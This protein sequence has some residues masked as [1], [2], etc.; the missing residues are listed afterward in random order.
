MKKEHFSEMS[1]EINAPR[2]HD[3]AAHDMVL[4]KGAEAESQ[5]LQEWRNMFDAILDPVVILDP[6]FTI[7]RANSAAY[8]VLADQ[9]QEILGRRCHTLFAGRQEPCHQCPAQDV[10]HDGCPHE[11]TINHGFLGRTFQVSCA[12]IMRDGKLVGIVHTA[13]DI[14]R[15]LQLE[16]QLLQAQ[17]MEAIATLAGG[18]AHD[19]NN[20]LGSILGNTDLLLYRLQ[21]AA[22]RPGSA[23]RLPTQGEIR[24]HLEAIKTAGLRARDLVRQILAFSRRTPHSC[25]Y[26]L[27]SPI[28]KEAVKLLRAS[29]PATIELKAEIAADIATIYGDPTQIHQVLMDLCT[30]AVQALPNQQGCIEIALRQI[31]AGPAEQRRYHDLLPGSYVLLSVKDNGRGIPTAIRDRIFDPFFTTRKVGEGTGLG[32]AAI[33]GIVNAHKGIVDVQSEEGIGTVFTLF[34]PVSKPR[35]NMAAAGA[36]GKIPGGSETILYVDDEEDIVK[37]RARML[38]YLGYHVIPATS[39][40][41]ALDLFRQH[42]DAINL[43]IT[44]HTMPRMTG[45]SLA[46]RIHQQRPDIPIILCSGYSE[47]VTTTDARKAGINR[48][49]AKPLDMRVLAAVIRE[50]VE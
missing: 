2:L 48:F 46:S 43:V 34:F 19:F 20:I 42:Q 36:G 11:Q 21:G 17:K 24:H 4:E 23:G 44:D 37:M 8:R 41:Q 14:S 1:C 35:Q 27:L 3:L 25:E 16:K 47:A 9:G 6:E 5:A 22:G 50:L 7:W 38:E 32:L 31:E 39:G 12:P 30:N 40:E 10:F 45:L 13:R 49:L 26:I 29:L 15:R 18:I 33:H 28:I